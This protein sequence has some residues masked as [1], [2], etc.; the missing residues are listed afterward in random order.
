MDD[1]KDTN[2]EADAIIAEL[3]NHLQT[4][5]KAIR[6]SIHPDAMAVIL[7]PLFSLVPRIILR[8]YSVR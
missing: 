6:N 1:D 7:S 3:S 5:I 2:P 8:Y 4:N